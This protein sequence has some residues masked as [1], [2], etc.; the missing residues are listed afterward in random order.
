MIIYDIPAEMLLNAREAFREVG[1]FANLIDADCDKLT[2]RLMEI[3]DDCECTECEEKEGRIENLEEEILA[4]N[5]DIEALK[6]ELKSAKL[7]K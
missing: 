2:L 5:E 7:D 3:F 1:K 4:L 6:D